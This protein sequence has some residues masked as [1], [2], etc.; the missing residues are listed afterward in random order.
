M[1]PSAHERA[2]IAWRDFQALTGAIHDRILALGSNYQIRF[3]G[4]DASALGLFEADYADA[5]IEAQ[6]RY[7]SMEHKRGTTQATT[8]AEF[9]RGLTRQ[10]RNEVMATTR[11]SAWNHRKGAYLEYLSLLATLAQYDPANTASRR[12]EL[13]QSVS[14]RPLVRRDTGVTQFLWT[15]P[16]IPAIVS[17]MKARPDLLIAYEPIISETSVFTIRESKHRRLQAATI[18]SEFGKAFDLRVRSYVLVSY[19]RVPRKTC[20][21]ANQLGLEV[22]ALDLG[23][24]ER[25]PSAE[26]L[27]EKV[28]RG[29]RSA[30]DTGRFTA[31]LITA[32]ERSESKDLVRRRRE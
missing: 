14:Q 3:H 13:T 21:A 20:M 23:E 4:Q 1:T 2:E 15:Q 28:V 17:G 9:A 29:F 31:M 27:S 12:F 22:E 11:V 5:E 16:T 24:R 26:D 30:D 7:L 25:R 32:A 6:Q 8:F 19:Y 18:R 10:A